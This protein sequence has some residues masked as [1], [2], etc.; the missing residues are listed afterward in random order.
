MRPPFRIES[1]TGLQAFDFSNQ[2]LKGSFGV[3]KQHTVAGM[4]KEVIVDG[5]I[6]FTHA[7]FH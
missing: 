2:F 3:A 1:G 5:G 7:S 4:V 6:T